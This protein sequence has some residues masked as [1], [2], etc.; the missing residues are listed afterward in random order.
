MP[1]DR[2]WLHEDI[3]L[4]VLFSVLETWNFT[5]AELNSMTSFFHAERDITSPHVQAGVFPIFCHSFFFFQG[6]LFFFF[7]VLFSNPQVWAIFT[8]LNYLKTK[9]SLSSCYCTDIIFFPPIKDHI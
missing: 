7:P 1:P 2:G 9:F 6:L 3:S 5:T 4:G 8:F